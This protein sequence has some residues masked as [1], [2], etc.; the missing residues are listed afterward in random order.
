MQQL[1]PINA[2]SKEVLLG[3]G[4]QP[5]Q[6]LPAAARGRRSIFG[7]WESVGTVRRWWQRGEP[8]GT[9]V[10]PGLPALGFSLPLPTTSAARVVLN[11]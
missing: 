5:P 3:P 10:L 6:T 8:P 11:P 4:L 7:C 2:F 1:W 9:L